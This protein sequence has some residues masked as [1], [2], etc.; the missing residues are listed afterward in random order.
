MTYSIINENKL[1]G[2]YFSQLPAGHEILARVGCPA[3]L[4]IESSI[5]ELVRPSYGRLGVSMIAFHDG[6]AAGDAVYGGFTASIIVKVEARKGD[7]ESRPTIEHYLDLLERLLA[8][9]PTDFDEINSVLEEVKDWNE[10]L[11][12]REQW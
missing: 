1:S 3:G 12:P 10:K 6:N 7:E 4:R 5:F 11:A 8:A 2:D 9:M